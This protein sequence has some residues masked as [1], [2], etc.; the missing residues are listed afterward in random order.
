MKRSRRRPPLP[1][2]ETISAGGVVY[3]AGPEGAEIALVI[4]DGPG[5]WALPKGAPHQGESIEAT[6]AR[7]VAEETGLLVEPVADLGEIEYWFVS[8]GESV[9]YHKRVR[10]YL[11]RAVGGSTAD[12]DHEY[13]RVEWLPIGI[14]PEQM[15]YENEAAVVRRAE[16]MLASVPH[17]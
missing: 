17:G 8:R 14:A 15:S 9:R 3:R 7:E 12:H 10:H 11:F 2:K 16:E 5:I 13:D 1:T 4:R 6:A